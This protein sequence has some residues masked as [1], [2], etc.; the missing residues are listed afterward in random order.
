MKRLYLYCRKVAKTIWRKTGWARET[1]K[2]VVAMFF[3][4][5]V[6]LGLWYLATKHGLLPTIQQLDTNLPNK[7]L[8]Q[9]PPRWIGNMLASF[10]GG[11]LTLLGGYFASLFG[12]RVEREKIERQ[13]RLKQTEPYRNY[14]IFLKSLLTRRTLYETYSDINSTLADEIKITNEDR[15]KAVLEMPPIGNL[16]LIYDDDL[17]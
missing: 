3:A 13:Q 14:L 11:V 4:L 12:K 2:F 5:S 8:P 16:S 1:I 10:T 17:Q 6:I 9:P 7:Q 15:R